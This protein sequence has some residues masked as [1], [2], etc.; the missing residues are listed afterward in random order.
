MSKLLLVWDVK[1]KCQIKGRWK[2][3]KAKNIYRSNQVIDV[4]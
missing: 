3:L 4:F 1:R 2:I